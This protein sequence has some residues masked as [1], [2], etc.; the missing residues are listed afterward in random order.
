MSAFA[1]DCSDS[2]RVQ[3]GVSISSFHAHTKEQTA[4]KHVATEVQ[5]IPSEEAAAQSDLRATA[6]KFPPA[7]VTLTYVAVVH[8]DALPIVP[9]PA[10]H[11][12]I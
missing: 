4:R 9:A 5:R 11:H 12:V 6:I 7:E 2:T 3:F 10:F 1:T 8:P